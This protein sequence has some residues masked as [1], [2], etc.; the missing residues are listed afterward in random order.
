MF[1]CPSHMAFQPVAMLYL[2]SVHQFIRY[3]LCTVIKVDTHLMIIINFCFFIFFLN[4]NFSLH[5][6]TDSLASSCDALGVFWPHFENPAL[7]I[8]YNCV[9]NLQFENVAMA[10]KQVNACVG[11]CA[12]LG[13]LFGSACMAGCGIIVIWHTKC[14]NWVR[15][16]CNCSFQNEWNAQHRWPLICCGPREELY[17]IT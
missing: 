13:S 14:T 16:M 9:Y 3:V 10:K 4:L 11:S 2:N 12:E 17:R 5:F 8:P 15:D 7:I 1:Y 6:F